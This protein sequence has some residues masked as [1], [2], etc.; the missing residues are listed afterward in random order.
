MLELVHGL[1]LFRAHFAAF[2]DHYVVIGGTASEIVLNQEA[3]DFR[4]TKDIDIVLVVESLTAE[5]AGSFW[6]FVIDGDY[7]I[8]QNKE[9]RLNYYRFHRPTAAGFPVMLEL[10]CREPD[11]IDLQRPAVT[12]PLPVPDDIRSLSAILL[13][14]EYYDLILASR[15]VVDGICVVDK[16]ALIQLKGKAWMDLSDRKQ[17][18]EEVKGDDV[19]KHLKDVLRFFV[20]LPQDAKIEIRHDLIRQ[21]MIEFVA[22]L[23]T[24]DAE[25]K[26]LNPLLRGITREDLSVRFAGIFGF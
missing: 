20:T 9:G 26:N 6:K 21:D 12:T 14:D 17:N 1:D 7:T 13:N 19:K 4:V 3:I 22:R 24:L 5:F 25:P 16:A 8:Y 10:L 23:L 15:S 11:G 2:S 18:G